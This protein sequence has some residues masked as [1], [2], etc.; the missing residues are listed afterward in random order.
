M[1]EC[2]FELNIISMEWKNVKQ[3][4]KKIGFNFSV[5]SRNCFICFSAVSKS[6][7]VKNELSQWLSVFCMKNLLYWIV[8]KTFDWKLDT[9]YRLKKNPSKSK[10]SK[11]K[12]ELV[13][14]ILSGYDR[15]ALY[16]GLHF[17]HAS[18]IR[19]LLRVL[20]KWDW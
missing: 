12:V 5:L 8:Q 6:S 20:V 14:L 17:L 13:G 10:N 4:I 9:R 15:C 3:N 16:D 11:T 1:E 2:I 19:R 18:E 7:T